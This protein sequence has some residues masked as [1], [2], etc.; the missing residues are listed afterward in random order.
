M[1]R[2]RG[3]T[4]QYIAMILRDKPKQHVRDRI[5]H[6]ERIVID[7]MNANASPAVVQSS[8]VMGDHYDAA[9]PQIAPV[10]SHVDIYSDGNDTTHYDVTQRDCNPGTAS[11]M[12]VNKNESTYVGAS[13]WAAILNDVGFSGLYRS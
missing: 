5:K 10:L 2:G 7:L 4:C 9:C 3:A 1:K 13:H 8:D 11:Q 12:K 6:L